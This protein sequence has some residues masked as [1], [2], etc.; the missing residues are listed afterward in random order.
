[1][2]RQVLRSSTSASRRSG[3]VRRFTKVSALSCLCLLGG[4]GLAQAATMAAGSLFGSPSQTVAVCY[5]FNSGETP[6]TISRFRITTR[7]EF[8]P[9]LTVNECGNFPATLAGGKS[10]GIAIAANNQ[11]FNCAAEV[12]P[13]KADMR[14]SFEMRNGSGLVLQNTPMR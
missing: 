6:V 9:A 4:A 12:G 7:A 8:A 2:L 10:C 11:A 5:L 1:M 14:G 13:G 3:F